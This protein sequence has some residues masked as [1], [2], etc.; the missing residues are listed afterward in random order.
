MLAAAG[1]TLLTFKSW[2]E[3]SNHSNSFS[4]KYTNFLNNYLILRKILSQRVDGRA[5]LYEYVP[6]SSA[7]DI[8]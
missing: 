5:I 4:V 7:S 2:G 8:V 3:F 1:L 6:D